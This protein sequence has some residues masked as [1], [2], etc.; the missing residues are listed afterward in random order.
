[1]RT[2]FALARVLGDPLVAS[3]SRK[4][5]ETVLS[6]SQWLP[7]AEYRFLAVSASQSVVDRNGSRWSLPIDRVVKVIEV[8]G[9]RL[10][11][12]FREEMQ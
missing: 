10:G 5:Q 11:L 12:V 3:I 4:D 6:V 1:V 2:V 7:V 8:L 9:D